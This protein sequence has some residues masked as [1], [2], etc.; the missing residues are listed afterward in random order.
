MYG[1]YSWLILLVTSKNTKCFMI[2][3]TFK[4]LFKKIIVGIIYSS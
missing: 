3:M 4:K 1:D 2:V